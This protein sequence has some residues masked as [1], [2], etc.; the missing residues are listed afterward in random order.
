MDGLEK[1][2]SKGKSYK[3]DEEMKERIF[4]LWQDR[5]PTK[6][7]AIEVGL[8]YTSVYQ[9]LKKRCLVG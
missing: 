3:I 7:I 5:L 9:E 1:S 2:K 6:A 4:S 8:S